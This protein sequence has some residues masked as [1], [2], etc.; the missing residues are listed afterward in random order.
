M[1]NTT[2]YQPYNILTRWGIFLALFCCIFGH[3][4]IYISENTEFFISNDTFISE[5][6]KIIEP[7]RSKAEIHVSNASFISNIKNIYNSEIINHND[8]KK[9]NDVTTKL[10]SKPKFISKEE[11]IKTSS[12]NKTQENK[13]LYFQKPENSPI[14]SVDQET[15][16]SFAPTHQQHIIGF[17][18]A[19]LSVNILLL[20]SIAILTS[21]TAEIQSCNTLHLRV[22]PP[23]TYQFS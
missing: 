22:R 13:G 15:Y 10:P 8:L 11:K 21:P 6:I 23:P 1:K 12:T 20:T 4:Q 18:N 5:E 9:E 14:F 17:H 19:Q 7:Q 16:K 3:A 2:K